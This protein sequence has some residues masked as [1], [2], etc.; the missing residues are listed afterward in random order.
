MIDPFDRKKTLIK[1]LIDESYPD[2]ILKNQNK[3]KDLIVKDDHV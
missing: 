2:Y 1:V 3:Y